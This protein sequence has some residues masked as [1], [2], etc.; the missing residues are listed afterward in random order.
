MVEMYERFKKDVWLIIKRKVKGRVYVQYNEKDDILYIRVINKD[1]DYDWKLKK[2]SENLS[3]SGVTKESVASMFL[4]G[5]EKRID[6]ISK[7]RYIKFK[8]KKYTL[9]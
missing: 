2:F 6:I 9:K 1:F 5:Y 8:K 7:R 4:R 3:S